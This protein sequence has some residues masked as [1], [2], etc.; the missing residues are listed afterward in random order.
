MPER[1]TDQSLAEAQA[2]ID[3]AERDHGRAEPQAPAREFYDGL[4]EADLPVVVLGADDHQQ[5]QG[6][7]GRAPELADISELIERH[8]VEPAHHVGCGGGVSGRQHGDRSGK[9]QQAD[10]PQDRARQTGLFGEVQAAQ[11]SLAVGQFDR[12]LRHHEES[13]QYGDAGEHGGGNGDEGAVER[14]DA[15]RSRQHQPG[16]RLQEA[17]WPE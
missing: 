13:M 17:E 9:H 11:T 1:V 10:P 5:C 12:A 14:N 6:C 8:P 2:Q 4:A 16:H 15:H 7:D 3:D